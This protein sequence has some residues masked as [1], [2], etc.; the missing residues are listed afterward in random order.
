MERST[1]ATLTPQQAMTA[2][3]EKVGI[4][5]KRIHCF[6]DQIVVT[7][8][9]RDAAIKWGVLLGRFAK[10]RATVKTCDP[11]TDQKGRVNTRMIDVYRTF[12]RIGGVA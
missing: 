8:W 7:S 2:K 1:P 3:L 11:A 4:P 10:V 9:S 6:G 12:A 5:F